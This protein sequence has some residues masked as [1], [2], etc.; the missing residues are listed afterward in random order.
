M[1]NKK[2]LKKEIKFLKSII[3]GMSWLIESEKDLRDKEAKLWP[4]HSIIV[5]ADNATD[6]KLLGAFIKEMYPDDFSSFDNLDI[7]ILHLNYFHF[8]EHGW[9]RFEKKDLAVDQKLLKLIT[10]YELIVN[11]SKTSR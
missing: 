8:T 2:K 5:E 4:F 9:H 1:S 10:P 7:N 11:Y 3:E 6:K